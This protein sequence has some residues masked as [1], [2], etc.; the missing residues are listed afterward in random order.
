MGQL[1]KKVSGIKPSI[2]LAV[3]AKAIAL[4]MQGHDI[5]DLGVGEPDFDTPDFIKEAAIKAI[6]NG[7]TK[8]TAVDGISSLK[9]AIIEKFARE[10]QLVYQT[11]QIIV[12]C[13]AKHSLFNAFNAL[14]N[15]GDEVIIPAPYWV[16][17]PDMVVLADGIPIFVATN[18]EQRFKMS[19]EQL[20]AAITPKTRLVILNSPSNPSGMAYSRE[21]LQALG[22]ILMEN[23]NVIVV[24]DD[25]YE[26]I[27]WGKEPFVN[28]VNVCPELYDRTIVVNGVSKAYAMTGWRI[29]YAAG[30]A[31][32][33]AVMRNMQSQSTSN[34]NSIAQVAAE[35]ALR[36]NQSF[37]QERVTKFKNRHDFLVPNINH[38]PGMRC[39]AA[40][41]TFYAFVSVEA[42]LEKSRLQNDVALSEYLLE[43]AQVA[44]VPGSG[45]G[46]P[47][48]IRLSYATSMEQLKIALERIVLAVEKLLHN[49]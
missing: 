43:E 46:V 2:T 30:D 26:H 14:L 34:P 32:I 20:Q 42:L 40:D 22:A 36:G 25:I 27:F 21:E 18:A 39:M 7:F 31:K 11:N 35:T 33:I 41:G 6:R 10:N 49:P 17:Y 1:S 38:I 16:S 3:S 24:T 12:S 4:K 5:I 9:Q 48:H 15:P 13:G 29:G 44:V 47:G 19:A 28:I 37:L 23:P 8:Y 45:F